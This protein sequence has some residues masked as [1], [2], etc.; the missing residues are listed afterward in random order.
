MNVVLDTNVI[1]SGLLWKSRTKVLFDLV[2]ERK[3]KLCL[4]FKILN[5]VERVLNYH[6]IRKQL[7]SIGL[8]AAEILGYLLQVSKIYPDIE[9]KAD[10]V[11]QSDKIFL[12][13][14]FASNAEYLITGDK[15]L[16]IL[17]SFQGTKIIK[18]RK[19]LEIIREV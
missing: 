12:G 13:V 9:I 10:I 19:F 4:T 5:E 11:D 8:T 6:H 14:V 3:I 1:V 18:P 16:L 2:D 17:K 7:N 15:H